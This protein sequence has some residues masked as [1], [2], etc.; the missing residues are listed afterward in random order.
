MDAGDGTNS[1][2]GTP[3]IRSGFQPVKVFCPLA[4]L[5]LCFAMVYADIRSGENRLDGVRMMKDSH[6]S[7]LGF[8]LRRN[9]SERFHMNICRKTA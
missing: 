7:R 2:T 1:A 3:G 4:V 9:L 5:G 8:R 6:R